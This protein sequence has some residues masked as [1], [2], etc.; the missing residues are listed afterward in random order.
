[1]SRKES[2][3]TLL[4]AKYILYSIGILIPLIL[5]IP[6]MA[7]GKISVLTSISWAVFTIG[8]IYFCLFQLAVYNTKTIP[9]NAKITGRQNSGSGLQSL[10]SGATFGIPL[11]LYALLKIWL[12]ETTTSWV[13]LVIGLG[14]ILTS[15]IWLKNVYNR[16]MKRRYKNMEG[17][18]DSRQ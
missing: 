4:R 7:M 1:M 11:L 15:R 14:F 12:G 3:Y 16:F 17:F 6:A 18:R 2:I 8:C 10:I 5:T 13:L 9:L